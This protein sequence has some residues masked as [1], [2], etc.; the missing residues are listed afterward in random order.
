MPCI[1]VDCFG[2][3]ISGIKQFSFYLPV[4]SGKI[5]IMATSTILSVERFTPVVSR[6]IKAIG[7]VNC[8]DI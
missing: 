5:F 2:I 7:R 1:S 4:P 8:K 6:S 3:G